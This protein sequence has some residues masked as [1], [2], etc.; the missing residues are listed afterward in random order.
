MD[1]Q[2]TISANQSYQANVYSSLEP[3]PTGIVDK[4]LNL[5]CVN[6]LINEADS[7]IGSS[8]ADLVNYGSSSVGANADYVNGG[9]AAGWTPGSG[10]EFLDPVTG[11]PPHKVNYSDIQRA[12]WSLIDND[13]S[14]SGLTGWNAAVADELADRAFV[15]GRGFTPD[16][17]D[18]VA[19]IL[20]PVGTGA[21]QQA[22]IAQVTLASPTGSC[23]G[24]DETGWAITNGIA[25]LG[26]NDRFGSSWAEYNTFPVSA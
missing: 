4:S 21:I 8:L 1:V 19:V 18:K 6:W 5:D 23:D 20:Q 13:Q 24:R 15:Y 3:V 12:I 26:G 16:C 10:A 17:N 22:T 7:L 11:T 14:T 25:G 2:H 9:S